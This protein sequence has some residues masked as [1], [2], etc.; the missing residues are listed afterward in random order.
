MSIVANSL[1]HDSDQ[2]PTDKPVPGNPTNESAL[3]ADV[4]PGL[5]LA[6]HKKPLVDLLNEF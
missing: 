6:I 2:L 3:A 1:I 4:L 5:E